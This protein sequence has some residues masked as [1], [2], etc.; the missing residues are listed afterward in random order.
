[1]S[2]DAV[3]TGPQARSG[4]TLGELRRRKRAGQPLP[5]EWHEWCD[6]NAAGLAKV[7][8]A[9]KKACEIE[10]LRGRRGPA[11]RSGPTRRRVTVRSVA[12]RRTTTAARHARAPASFII[13]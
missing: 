11:R 9:L 4:L 3:A 12:G 6:A 8:A 7:T 10:T 2:I 1:M 5:A 13:T